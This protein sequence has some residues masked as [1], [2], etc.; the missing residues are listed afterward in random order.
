MH[1][2]L[3]A[4]AKERHPGRGG[5]DN[6]TGRKA[7]RHREEGKE[8]GREACSSCSSSIGSVVVPLAKRVSYK[9]LS[10]GGVRVCVCACVRVCV[11]LRN[12]P[13]LC[14]SKF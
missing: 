7:R 2:S 5:G 1:A 13:A 6:E 14:T 10:G 3:R 4:G 9:H 8:G 11:S 12:R